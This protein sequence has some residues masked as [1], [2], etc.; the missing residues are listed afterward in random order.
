M[1][2]I[3]TKG[4]LFITTPDKLETRLRNYLIKKYGLVIHGKISPFVCEAIKEK[5]D[6]VEALEEEI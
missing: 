3:K 5:L 1:E 2:V 6:S 4:R